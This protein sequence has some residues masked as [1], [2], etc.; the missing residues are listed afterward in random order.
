MLVPNSPLTA[1]GD[2]LAVGADAFEDRI[3]DGIESFGEESLRVSRTARFP[4]REFRV[5]EW[6]LAQFLLAN[7]ENGLRVCCY[8]DVPGNRYAT[9]H[10]QRLHR[11]SIYS[12]APKPCTRRCMSMMRKYANRVLLRGM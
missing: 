10:R 8:R 6:G 1:F 11:N 3:L 9:L 12:D 7:V 5:W 4:A 2:H